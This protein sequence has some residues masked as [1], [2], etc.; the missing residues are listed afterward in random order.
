M[1]DINKARIC[2]SM[3]GA[4]YLFCFIIDWRVALF[5]LVGAILQMINQYYRKRIK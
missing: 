3:A 5:C 2:E 4:L 1:K